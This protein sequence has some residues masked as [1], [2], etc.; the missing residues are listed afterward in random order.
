MPRCR[1]PAARTRRRDVICPMITRVAFLFIAVILTSVDLGACTLWGAAGTSAS[2]GTVVSK[3]RDWKPD[4]TQV[5]RMHRGE[6]GHAYFG[7]WTVYAEKSTEGLVAGVNEKGLTVFTAAAGSIPK[8]MWEDRP[9]RRSFTGALLADYAS[10]DE[11]LAKRDAIFPALRPVF[12]MISDRKK[13]LSVEVGLGGKYA[14]KTIEDDVVA[15]ANH[16]LDD[17][18][19]E[20]NINVGES[21]PK[22]F[23]RISHLLKM[24]P[25]PFTA[26]CF[27]AMGKDQHDGPDNSLWRTGKIART[28]ASWIVETPAHGAPKLRVVI[29][30]PG[31]PEQIRSFVLDER[32]WAEAQ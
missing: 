19:A 16:F 22:R 32:F 30:N 23:E 1:G 3:N 5:L 27:S 20:F 14:V 17:S 24:S 25:R 21:S 6:K 26:E 7:L 15:H 13:I 11:V 2:G 8:G 18:L 31:Q 9:V 12:I 10:C 29:A 28:L 4:H